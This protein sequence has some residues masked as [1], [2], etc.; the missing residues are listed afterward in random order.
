MLYPKLSAVILGSL[1]T[2]CHAE[3]PYTFSANTPAKATEVNSNFRYLA[4]EIDQ[5]KSTDG[6]TSSGSNNT[7]GGDSSGNTTGSGYVCADNTLDY[8]YTYQKQTAA[9]GT[10]FTLGAT[11]YRLVKYRV[12]DPVNG[13]DYNVTM[14]V[15]AYDKEDGTP[16][17]RFTPA[18]VMK[19]TDPAVVCSGAT[20]SGFPTVFSRNTGFTLYRTKHFSNFGENSAHEFKNH[21]E[22]ATLS[23]SANVA[24]GSSYIAINFYSPVIKKHS[25]VVSTGDYDFT[26]DEVPVTDD[27]SQE[28]SAISNLLNHI[29]IEKVQ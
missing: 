18:T 14:P 3:L 6:N 5:L 23:F 24:L 12:K 25:K 27:F 10:V 20:F 22:Q 13:D 7:S 8:P 17:V 29:I 21:Y 16:Y 19:I 15:E 11:E 2:F 4:D 1:A 28:V 9:L 26:N